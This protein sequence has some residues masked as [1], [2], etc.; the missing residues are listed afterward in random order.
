MNLVAITGGIGSGKT[1]FAKLFQN[2]G[3]P[4]F[5]ADDQAKALMQNA[6]L[7]KAKIIDVFGEMSYKNGEL[8]RPYLANLVF[9]DKTNLTKLNKIV[10]PAVKAH[11]KNWLLMQKS[12]YI[13]YENAILFE[14]NTAADFDFI[15]CVTADLE[16][17]I[18]RIIKRDGS[19]RQQALSR[20]ENQID[21]NER[22]KK[23]DL[24][25]YNNSDENLNKEVL[26]IHQS[27]LKLFAK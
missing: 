12:D 3:I 21:D 18:N 24:V 6:T 8:N 16:T 10:H 13:I 22:I 11:F 15:I 2:L 7:L 1:H 5:F 14:T 4:V 25:V 27:L 23:S 17:R 26:K 20:I 9:N 19:T